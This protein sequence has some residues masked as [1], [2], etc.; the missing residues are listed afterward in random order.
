MWKRESKKSKINWLK[1]LRGAIFLG[2]ALLLLSLM[3]S[4]SKRVDYRVL[5]QE[6]IVG[7]LTKDCQ[8]CYPDMNNEYMCF[9]LGNISD[10]DQLIVLH[11]GWYIK[12]IEELNFCYE[13]I[14]TDPIDTE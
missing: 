10:L 1:M 13:K 6:R 5:P 2:L 4:C 12:M 8:M 9:P 7:K 11:L 14:G 3:I